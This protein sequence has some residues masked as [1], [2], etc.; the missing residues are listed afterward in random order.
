MKNTFLVFFGIS[1]FLGIAL[2]SFPLMP[3]M[4]CWKWGH[5]NG[6]TLGQM[7]RHISIYYCLA[8]IYLGGFFMFLNVCFYETTRKKA[9]STSRKALLSIKPLIFLSANHIMHLKFAW[10]FAWFTAMRGREEVQLMIVAL[11]QLD[12]WSADVGV[13]LCA[14]H[15]L[16]NPACWWGLC[17]VLLMHLCEHKCVTVQRCVLHCINLLSSLCYS[18]LKMLKFRLSLG[19]NM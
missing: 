16:W 2:L 15:W 17:G 18:L 4:R 6:M 1:C 14:C 5:S 10:Q 12:E 3:T 11:L 7:K 13:I 8:F 9:G 19:A